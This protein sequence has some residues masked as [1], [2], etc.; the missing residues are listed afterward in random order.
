MLVLGVDPGTAVTG[1]GLV[2]ADGRR[3]R[4]AGFGVI[5]TAGHGPLEERLAR[6]YEGVRAL[7]ERERPDLLAVEDPFTARNPRSALLLGQARGVVVA[8]GASCGVPVRG[9]SPRAVKLAVTG[10]GGAGKEQV[11][12]MVRILLGMERPPAPVDAA[13]GLAVAICSIT[14]GWAGG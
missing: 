11:R 7:L 6:I 14:S 2:R 4:G 5:R 1:W 8:A 13:D 12:D 9:Y 3:L 10:D